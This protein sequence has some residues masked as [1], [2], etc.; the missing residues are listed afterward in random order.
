[1]TFP[2]HHFQNHFYLQMNMCELSPFGLRY[3]YDKKNSGGIFSS[4]DENL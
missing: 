1:M 2:T 3:L 4:L